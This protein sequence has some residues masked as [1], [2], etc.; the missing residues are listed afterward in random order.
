MAAIATPVVAH[1]PRG[2]SLLRR[3]LS[4]FLA[5]HPEWWVYVVAGAAWVALAWWSWTPVGH[6][7]LMVPAMMLPVV[8]HHV[9]A[10]GLRSVWSRRH[11]STFV[12][13]LAYL[14]AWSS[15]GAG[16]V[17]AL[18][19]LGVGHHGSHLLPVALLLAAAWQVSV[20]RRRVV[21]RCAPLRLGAASGLAADRDCAVAGV[22]SAGRCMVECWPVM[23][24]M[25]LSHSLVLMVGLTAVLL[26]ERARGA[27]PQRRGGR[28]L[29]AWVLAG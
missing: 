13:V 7:L 5:W 24:A 6:W 9:R 20:P 8:A 4:R 27:N 10:V 11:R 12:F 28:P 25:A 22:R 29:E 3:S 14:A 26:S 2:V 17:L 1:P 16:V 18:V 21:R 23:L 19:A 15:V